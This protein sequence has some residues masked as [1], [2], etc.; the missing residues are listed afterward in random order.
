M[1][2]LRGVM[3][4]FQAEQ[5]LNNL[6]S[7]RLAIGLLWGCGKYIHILRT[8]GIDIRRTDHPEGICPSTAA[9]VLL[10]KYKRHFGIGS[11]DG[12]HMNRLVS[13]LF[14]PKDLIGFPLVRWWLGM[15]FG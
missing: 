5:F 14:L 6:I 4:P 10:G 1:G 3:S 9:V 12:A 15:E 11:M 13:G 2:L 8:K 7:I